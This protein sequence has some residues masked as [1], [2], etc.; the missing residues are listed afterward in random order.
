MIISYYLIH[1]SDLTDGFTP[2]IN[3]CQGPKFSCSS[4]S[5][6]K[7]RRLVLEVFF[8]YGNQLFTPTRWT[9]VTPSLRQWVGDWPC[10]EWWRVLISN[11]T[12]WRSDPDLLCS[13]GW[14][15]EASIMLS[16][17]CSFLV[18][19]VSEEL[20][21]YV[22][23]WL[24]LCLCFE[25]WMMNATNHQSWKSKSNLT[26]KCCAVI[27]W[28]TEIL[29]RFHG[30]TVPINLFLIYNQNIFVWLYDSWYFRNYLS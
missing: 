11:R 23:G 16:V 7:A 14:P 5:W 4:I 17:D 6:S 9:K 19:R 1:D 15:A 2:L 13:C 21:E 25:W 30:S 29:W 26:M 22:A 24:L 12:C 3:F 27:P 8:K 28:R 18:Y 20:T 10:M